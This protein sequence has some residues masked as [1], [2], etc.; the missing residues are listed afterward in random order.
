MHI[1]FRGSFQGAFGA[2][3]EKK[4]LVPATLDVTC[5]KFGKRIGNMTA[6]FSSALDTSVGLI[7]IYNKHSYF[8]QHPELFRW[9]KDFVGVKEGVSQPE[10]APSP[11]PQPRQERITG[12]AA[13]EIGQ[14]SSYCLLNSTD[15]YTVPVSVLLLS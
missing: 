10:P 12:D 11:L 5:T 8:F 6:A 9:F 1:K 4:S 15:I 2:V 3:A 7:F 14:T 13:M